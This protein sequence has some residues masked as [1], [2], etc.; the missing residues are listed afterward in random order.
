MPPEAWSRPTG[1][2]I[3]QRP[4]W[5]SV[6]ARWRETEFHHVDLDAGYRHGHWPAEFVSLMLPRVLATLD[7][8]LG[9]ET[10]VQVHTA[11]QQW[12]RAGATAKP[13]RQAIPL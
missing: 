11:G 8:R 2:R 3:G 1:A 12:T 13:R 5:K 4:A 7:A 9:D 10:D 6:W